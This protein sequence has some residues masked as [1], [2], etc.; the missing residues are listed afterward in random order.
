[1]LIFQIKRSIWSEKWFNYVFTF[2]FY[3][4]NIENAKNLGQSDN[5]LNGKKKDGLI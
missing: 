1:M 2:C 5:M 3:K 4:K